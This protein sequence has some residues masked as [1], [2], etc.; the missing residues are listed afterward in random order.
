MLTYFLMLFI[1]V[2]FAAMSALLPQTAECKF[3]KSGII[4][5]SHPQ[6]LMFFISFIPLFLVS[7]MRYMIGVDYNSYAWIFSAITSLGEK[8]HVEIGYE[9]LNR[10][11]GFFTSDFVWVFVLTSGI[12]IVFFAAAI[13][14]N[15]VTPPLSLFLFAALGYFFYS[16]NSVR[17][18][19]ALSLFVFA[20]KYMKKQQFWR[21]LAA[22]LIAAC[23]HK[24]ALIA[25]PIYLVFTRKFKFSYYVMIFAV[26][27][28]AAIFNKQI[29]NIIFSFVY[30]SYKNSVYNVYDFSIFNVLLCLLASFFA[31]AYYKPLLE[32]CKSNIIL[33]NSA[34]FMLLFY[35]T[36]WWIPTPSRIGHFGT[37]L[38]IFLF[39]AA[40]ECEK[41]RKVRI[42]Y[43]ILLIVFS[44]AF[45]IVMLINAQN[46]NV[47]LVPYRSVFDR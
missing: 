47:G 46:P 37:I 19:M 7:A 2:A 26:L 23:F 3:N 38:F 42:L 43:Y 5:K 39:P 13:Y 6:S 45:M 14:E 30:S 4:F 16:M 24:I 11:I 33:I 18:F 28:A 22:I 32:R 27:C 10:L 44:I 35:L 31:V 41:S 17:H 15:S 36:C 12:I 20:L 29:L 34:I 21:F 9:L 1:S 40:I 25:I 8:T